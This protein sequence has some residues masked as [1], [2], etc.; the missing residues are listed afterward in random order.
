MH[1]VALE[2]IARFLSWAIAEEE[3]KKT[4]ARPSLTKIPVDNGVRGVVLGFLHPS[5]RVTVIV[6]AMQ[7]NARHHKTCHP[8]CAARDPPTANL[9]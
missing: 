1:I 2:I 3:K 8:P 7:D 5:R 4:L 9:L 6:H